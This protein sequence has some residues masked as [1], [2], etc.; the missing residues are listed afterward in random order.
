M[1]NTA[2]V[3]LAEALSQGPPPR[4]N[5]AVPIFTRGSLEVELY[6]PK[7]HDP[8]KPHR[9]DEIYLVARGTASFFDGQHRHEVSPGSFIFVA[10][11]QL[12]RFERSSDDFAVWVFFYGPDGGEATMS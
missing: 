1:N 10:A 5:L 2:R 9:R 7:G 4:G 12:H 6:T 8:Q 11:G 3:S